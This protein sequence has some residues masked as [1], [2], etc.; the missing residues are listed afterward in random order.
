MKDVLLALKP[1]H[2]LVSIGWL[3]R[4][5]GSDRTIIHDFSKHIYSTFVDTVNLEIVSIYMFPMLS[6]C[7][8]LMV[9]P[10]D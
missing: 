2:A 9:E 6:T 4:L 5:A 10:R 7:T 3:G 1:S 8:V